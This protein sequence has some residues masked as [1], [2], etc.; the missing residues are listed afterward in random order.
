MGL[1]SFQGPQHTEWCVTNLITWYHAVTVFGFWDI[2]FLCMIFSSSQ[3]LKASLPCPSS[4]LKQAFHSRVFSK[5]PLFY[6][7]R[8]IL[9]FNDTFISNRLIIYLE[10]TPYYKLSCRRVVN[11]LDFLTFYLQTSAVSSIVYPIKICGTKCNRILA[12]IA[13]LI[14]QFWKKIQASLNRVVLFKFIQIQYSNFIIWTLY[15]YDSKFKRE[16]YLR[17]CLSFLPQV[18]FAIVN[19]YFNFIF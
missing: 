5:K 19:D 7:L 16:N 15:L 12:Y 13:E 11:C 10:T 8:S 2:F 4:A 1:F 3:K 9:Y 17:T 18:K 6:L 14:Q